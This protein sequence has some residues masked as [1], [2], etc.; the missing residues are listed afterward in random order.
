MRRLF[1]HHEYLCSRHGYWLGP[2][3]P[4]HDDTPPRLAT[5]LPE[6]VT[7]QHRL[8]HATVRHGWAAIFDATVAATRICLD[9]RFSAGG[10][11][12]WTR[13]EQRLDL[14]MPAGYRRSLFMAAIF[15]EVVALAALICSPPWRAP[16][17]LSHPADLER[18]LSAAAHELDCPDTVGGLADAIM[19]W[20]ATRAA[21]APLE[22]VSIY[23]QTSHGDDGAPRVT[24]GQRLAEQGT[25]HRFARD[26][27]APRANS[28]A[29]PLPYAHRP[30]TATVGGRPS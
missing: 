9:L 21:A 18:F 20:A 11:P 17:A 24:D 12:L 2:P 15:P 22:P 29:A 23:P 27:R 14:L 6:L 4:T 16:A 10:H 13:W 28:P 8:R 7:A 19:I 26:R 3:D 25:V 30:A 5:R 1:A